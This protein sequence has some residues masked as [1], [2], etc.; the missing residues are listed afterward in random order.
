M[1]RP[2]ADYFLKAGYVERLEPRYWL[3]ERSEMVWQPDVYEEAAELGRRLCAPALVDIG[4]GN[5]EKVAALAGEFA[6]TGIDFGPNIEIC[7]RLHPG[8]SWLEADLDAEGPLEGVDARGAVVVCADVIEHL[9]RPERLLAKLRNL[10]SEGAAALIL[11][12]P[13][14]DLRR[15]TAHLGPSPNGAHVREWNSRELESFMRASSL[16]A[17]FGLT[18]TN[19]AA[20]FLHTIFAAVPGEPSEG[21]DAWWRYRERWQQIAVDLQSMYTTL[22]RSTWSRAGRRLNRLAGRR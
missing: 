17:R 1:P 6:I 22:E 19:D 11:T 3:D 20:P 18:R 16:E 12:T 15:G 2:D 8:M 4:C 5:G 13:E 7:R 21:F 14:R 9:V 10:L